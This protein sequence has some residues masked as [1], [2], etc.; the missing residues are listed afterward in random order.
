MNDRRNTA[1][2]IAIPADAGSVWI[3][4]VKISQE[5][6]KL[7]LNPFAKEPSDFHERE[8]DR[9]FTLKK[10]IMPH[11]HNML[12][13]TKKETTESDAPELAAGKFL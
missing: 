12:C 11:L 7:I 3:P 8:F 9:I 13:I 6:N 2:D 10:Y 5:K 1:K 4:C